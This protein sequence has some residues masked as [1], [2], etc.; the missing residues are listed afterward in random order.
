MSSKKT[1]IGIGLIGSTLLLSGLS[2][3]QTYNPPQQ[4]TYQQPPQ[5]NYGYC[6][7]QA[8]RMSGY[9]GEAPSQYRD[10]HALRKAAKQAQAVDAIAWVAGADKKKRK[11]LRKKAALDGFLKGAIQRGVEKDRN[12]KARERYDYELRACMSGR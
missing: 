1:M 5:N 8:Q 10:A 11:K 9:Y 6:Q 4:P 12:R 7:Q 2:E 3:A